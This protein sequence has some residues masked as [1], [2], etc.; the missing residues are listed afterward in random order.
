MDSYLF[1]NYNNYC[2]F[3]MVKGDRIMD[4]LLIGVVLIIVGCAGRRLMK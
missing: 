4:L 1:S 3:K 2:D